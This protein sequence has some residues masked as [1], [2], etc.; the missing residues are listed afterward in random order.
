MTLTTVMTTVLSKGIRN[1]D[2]MLR[3]AMTLDSDLGPL[4]TSPVTTS[5]RYSIDH[6]HCALH[7]KFLSPSYFTTISRHSCSGFSRLSG[8][9]FP[10]LVVILDLRIESVVGCPFLNKFLQ[11]SF[12]SSVVPFANPGIDQP[13]SKLSVGA[14]LIAWLLLCHV[15]QYLPDLFIRKSTVRNLFELHK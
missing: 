9:L 12:H 3:S 2:T 6:D 13:L 15:V 7:K 4:N 8:H 11:K 14:D 5:G 10:L 1:H